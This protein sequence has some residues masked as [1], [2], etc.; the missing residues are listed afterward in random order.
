M[1]ISIGMQLYNKG[2][3][4]A[5][6]SVKAVPSIV[7]ICVF[8]CH[9]LLEGFGL[10]ISSFLLVSSLFCSILLMK[11]NTYDSVTNV[12]TNVTSHTFLRQGDS[13]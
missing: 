12:V 7:I 10:S 6:R 1:C 5:A 2:S 3:S 13:K 11:L 8:M 4:D 9:I